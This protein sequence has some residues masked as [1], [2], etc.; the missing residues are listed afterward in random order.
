MIQPTCNPS[1]VETGV[2]LGS[3]DIDLGTIG[4]TLT[5]RK[6]LEWIPVV[7][8][9]DFG[10]ELLKGISSVKLS[11]SIRRK[12]GSISCKKRLGA[13]NSNLPKRHTKSNLIDK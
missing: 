5:G 7:G 3:F 10:I 2:L 4:S 9:A 6:G 13:P 1:G 12:E 8:F 11:F